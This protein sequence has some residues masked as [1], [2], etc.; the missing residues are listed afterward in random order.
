MPITY[1]PGTN[2]ITIVGTK[3]GQPYTFEDIY[4]ADVSNGWGKF[5]KLSE[6]VYKTTA[7]LQF[8]DGSSETLFEEKGTTLIIEN[9]AT[10][11]NDIIVS[12]KAKCNAKFGEC[13]YVEDADDYEAKNGVT[14]LIRETNYNLP[15]FKI[16]YDSDVEFY[17]CA[18]CKT[19]DSVRYVQI[20]GH[21][22][23]FIGC[24]FSIDTNMVQNAV[25]RNCL[26][27]GGLVAEYMNSDIKGLTAVSYMDNLIWAGA[28]PI[29]I[30]NGTF[31]VS[32]RLLDTRIKKGQINRFINCRSNRWVVRWLLSEGEESGETQRI[33]AIRFKI[34]DV[35]GNPLANRVVK[36]YDKDGNLVA[37]TVTDENGLTDEV[38]ILYAKLTNPYSD[39]KWHKFTD[40]D[41]EYFNPFTVEVHYGNE[42]EYKGI[43]TDL[44]VN[45]TYIQIVVNPSKLTLDDV[46]NE[47]QAHRNAVEPYINEEVRTE[48]EMIRKIVGNDWE[49]KNNQLIIYDDDGE[50][51]LLVFDLYDRL[52]N[53]AEVNVF[54]RVKKK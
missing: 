12:F 20:R 53:P 8:G 45:S 47:I 15:H 46:M 42:L 19:A 27:N 5:T 31:I 13:T 41:W 1:D 48:I 23:K 4:Q 34:T 51:P 40:D 18:F 52:G 10:Q 33:Y 25:V 49:I 28:N 17:G 50:T 9:V 30:R 44:D 22:K 16:E 35:S 38:E 54:K 36:V 7:K 3:D 24:A 2:T 39:G 37:E 43:L 21:V 11:V 14:F 29:E 32:N 26:Y 6:G